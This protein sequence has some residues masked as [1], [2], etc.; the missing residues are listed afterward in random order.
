MPMVEQA[1]PFATAKTVIT[2]DTGYHSEENLRQLSERG[3]P[4]LIAHAPISILT[5]QSQSAIE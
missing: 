5:T 1:L 4:A 2:A 3:I